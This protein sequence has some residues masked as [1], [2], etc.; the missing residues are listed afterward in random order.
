MTTPAPNRLSDSKR[1]RLYN[2]LRRSKKTETFPSPNAPTSTSI[3]QQTSTPL[4]PALASHKQLASNK[5]TSAIPLTSITSDTTLIPTKA[6]LIPVSSSLSST[7]QIAT[8]Q[9]STPVSQQRIDRIKLSPLIKTPHKNPRVIKAQEELQRVTEE[10]QA[11]LVNYEKTF[12]GPILVKD[13]DITSSGSL[14]TQVATDF[15]K[16]VAQALSDHKIGESTV[17]GKVIGFMEKLYPITNIVLGIVSF[18]A[19]A[20][21]VV[22]LKLAANTLNVIV[23]QAAKQQTRSNGVIDCLNKL[24]TYQSFF[25][26]INRLGYIQVSDNMLEVS[27]NLLAGIMGTLRISLA[28]L[29]TS[30]VVNIAKAVRGDDFADSQQALTTAMEALD[31]AIQQELLFDEKERKWKDECKKTLDFLSKIPAGKM[32]HDIRNRRLEHS[33]EWIIKNETFQKWMNGDLKTLWC[34]GKPGAGK[35]FLASVIIDHCRT[36]YGSSNTE[37]ESVG[38]AWM[39]FNYNDQNANSMGQVIASLTKQLI[40]SVTPEIGKSI[41]ED[42]IEF[43]EEH[44]SGSPGPD[45]YFMLLSKVIRSMQKTILILDALD[46]CADKDSKRVNRVWLIKS[47]LTL[48]VQMLVTSREMPAIEALFE[49]APDFAMLAISPA[50]QDIKSYIQWRIYDM[51]YGSPNLRHLLKENQSLE[52]KLFKQWWKSILKSLI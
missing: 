11:E 50:S 40:A 13:E 6:A 14:P 38:I 36:V 25:Q 24:D 8:V 33:G 22:P 49:Q 10:L 5:L 35:T 51:K 12:P 9:Q 23:N 26:N 44:N 1:D 32:H 21:G 47:L 42:A 17:G 20:A 18:G 48:G 3:G 2:I 31:R 43:R 19:D 30:F 41:M 45:D 7:S 37:N 46:E 28:S 15:G 29:R 34:P 27:T 16:V 39:Y 4:A 52:E